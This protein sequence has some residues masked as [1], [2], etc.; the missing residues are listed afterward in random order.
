ME[1]LSPFFERTSKLNESQAWSCWCGYLSADSYELNH[2]NEYFTIRAKTAVIDISPLKKYIIEGPDSK[3]FL[4]YICTRNLNA[5]KIGQ[6]MYSPWCDEAGKIIDDGTIQRISSEMFRLT[7]A[8]S[9]FQW[10]VDNADNMNINIIDDSQ[11]TSC[12]AIQG[13]GSKKILSN[14]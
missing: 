1:N 6:V 7:S 8:E 10:L 5:C 11:S 2:H 12:L 9:N 13:P 4:N 14:I 3:K